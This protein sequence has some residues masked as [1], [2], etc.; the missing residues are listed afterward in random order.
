MNN[1]GARA[2]RHWQEWLPD[3]YAE[4]DGPEQFFDELGQYMSDRI[5]SLELDLLP[6]DYYSEGDFMTRVG[7]RNMA[8]LRAEEIVVHETLP[9]PPAEPDDD[10]LH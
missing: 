2:R 5:A 9:A 4:I 3:R 1:Y 7:H 6:R 10:G 8:R